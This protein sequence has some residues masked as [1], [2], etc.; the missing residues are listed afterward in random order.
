MPEPY[1]SA[2]GGYLRAYRETGRRKIIGIGREVTGL[3]RDGTVFPMYLGVSEVQLSGEVVF[4]GIARDLSAISGAWSRK[5]CASRT[6]SGAASAR[7]CTTDWAR[8]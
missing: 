6:K 5:S 7:T 3:R 8:C 1:R 4:T 2:H